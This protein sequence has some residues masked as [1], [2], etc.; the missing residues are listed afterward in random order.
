MD[1]KIRTEI[2]RQCA[3]RA[4]DA[5]ICPSEVARTL[6]P[7]EWRDH[8]DEVRLTGLQLAK[9]SII[10]IT[11]RGVRCDPNTEIR[12]ALRYGMPKSDSQ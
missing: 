10:Q 7:H 4:P 6:W 1:N 8:M 2:I 3:Q 12:G 5:T 11:Q 9:E